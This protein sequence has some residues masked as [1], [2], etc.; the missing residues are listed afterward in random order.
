MAV[1]NVKSLPKRSEIPVEHKWK[2][3]DIYDTVD[4][5][6]QDFKQVKES[7]AQLE[8]YKGKLALS[9]QELL[10]C[11]KRRDQVSEILEKLYVYA[12]MAKD[13]DNTNPVFQ[14]LRD[15][16]EGLAIQLDSA[17]SYVVPEI[18]TIPE[19]TLQK[20]ME[21]E[22]GLVL[23]RQHLHDILRRKAHTL[24]AREE[25]IIAMAGEVGQAPRNIFGMLNNADIKF[26]EILDE[27]GEKVQ[28]T[29]GRYI[30][31]MESKDRRVRK[32]AFTSLY[33]T[34]AKQKNTLAAILNGSVK[35]DIF[36]ARV[37]N[38][39][40]ALE[41]ALH[42]YNVPV[43]VYTNL[44]QAVR[45]KLDAMYRYVA[46]RKKALGLDQLHMYDIYT[47]IVKDVEMKTPYQ[48]ALTMVEQGLQP[49]GPDYLAILKKGF[50]SG[51]IDV[52]E[53]EGKTSGAY[54]WGAY[55]GHPY[56]LLN[57]QDN[58][59]N[60][61]TLAHEMGHALHSYYSWAAQ[62]Y[63]Y[64]GYKIFVAEVASTLNESL[65]T[66]YLLNNISDKNGQMYI[67]N[68]YLEQ[69]R[70]TVFRQTMFAEFEMVIHDKVEKGEALTVDVLSEVY[71]NLNKDYYGP[72]VAVDE[73]VALEW[74]RIPHFYS[75]FYVY[76]YATGFSAATALA[77][78]IL[79]EGQ[80]AVGRYLEF[81]KGGSSDY[82]IEL[83]KKTGVDMSSPEP[84]KAAL[85]VFD[86]M[87]ARMEELL[88][89]KG[90]S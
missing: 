77:K 27:A 79:E 36:Q 1:E 49:L 81:L 75:A 54:S 65:L 60:V 35:K 37:R 9:A 63:V 66:H 23:Y 73:E 11:L 70:G 90:I 48:E 74:A 21:E 33:G 18:L 24:S 40:S 34:Y 28:I 26:P 83:L 39:G 62:P 8:S 58:L 47:P 82:P 32:D 68:H 51:W 80:P 46:L 10:I 41:A 17:L 86:R 29:H 42:D 3:T 14:A 19:T 4:S 30:Q 56:V 50:T 25:Q 43:Q 44:I 64:G 76:K 84:V 5:W 15:R 20:Y 6:E 53:N 16:S 13:E 61:F 78:N 52:Y 87:V 67:L 2:L 85:E 38:Y 59:D 31:L 57:Y 88:N 12:Y 22:E 7:I 89:E 45:E 69:F 71:Y 72:D 55:G